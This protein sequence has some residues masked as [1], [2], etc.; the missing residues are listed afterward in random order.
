MI[1]GPGPGCCSTVRCQECLWVSGPC[2]ARRNLTDWEQRVVLWRGLKPHAGNS[3]NSLLQKR[4]WYGSASQCVSA[5][6]G[7]VRSEHRPSG[8][9]SASWKR[10]GTLGDPAKPRL[11]R[12][13]PHLS[14]F[15]FLCWQDLW[16]A[17][18]SANFLKTNKLILTIYLQTSHLHSPFLSSPAGFLTWNS[19]LDTATFKEKA[20]L[21]R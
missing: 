4:R 17:T 1:R 7:L 6:N 15:A 13:H 16:L 21:Y 18:L 9:H 19:T 11:H 5:K 10:R 14:T 8:A 20:R 12:E 2:G 3:H